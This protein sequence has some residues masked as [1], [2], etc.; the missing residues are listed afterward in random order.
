MDHCR[1]EKVEPG[2]RDQAAVNPNREELFFLVEISL[3]A[4][5]KKFKDCVIFKPPSRIQIKLPRLATVP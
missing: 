1:P 2:W 5:L 3:T 4:N